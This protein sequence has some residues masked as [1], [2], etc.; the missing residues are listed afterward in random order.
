MAAAHQ[1]AGEMN[2]R[3]IVRHLLLTH[4]Q[5]RHAF[6]R[7]TL[8]IIEEMIRKGETLHSAQLRFAVEGALDI[9]PLLKGQTPRERALAVFAEQGIWDTEH[10]DGVLIYLLLADHA[11]E[12]I[13]DRGVS[14]KVSADEWRAICRDMESEFKAGYYQA[15]VVRGIEAATWLLIKHYPARTADI[16]EL[17]DRPVVL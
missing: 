5:V 8:N 7:A 14:A 3:R 2:I 13:A 15:G 11:V 10:N 4:W 12:I 16:N 17:P 1:V 9:V 6:P